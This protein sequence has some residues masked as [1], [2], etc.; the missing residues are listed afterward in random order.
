[1]EDLYIFVISVIIVCIILY[2]LYFSNKATIH[3]KIK[4]TPIRKINEVQNGEL[5]RLKGKIVYAGRTIK[6]PLS[7]RKCVYY[8]VEVWKVTHSRNSADELIVEEEDG[9]DIVI[10]VDDH[11]AVISKNA[12]AAYI[13]LDKTV[14]SGFWNFSTDELEA[15]LKKHGLRTK[16]FMDWSLDLHAKEGVLEEGEFINILGK[17]T[18]RN[19]KDFRLRVPT[20]KVLY[21]EASEDDNVYLTEEV[22]Y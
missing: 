18:W 9:A 6:A 12:I 17:A 2:H 14:S 22:L 4:G 21:I 1:M 19:A 13:I 5:V 20:N 11:Y 16:G 3:N 7:K 15:L 8:R 10:E